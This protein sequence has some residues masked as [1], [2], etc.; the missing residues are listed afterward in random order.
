MK[1]K[2]EMRK[3]C[4]GLGVAFFFALLSTTTKAQTSEEIYDVPSF[5]NTTGDCDTLNYPIHPQWRR[6][7]YKYYDEDSTVLGFYNGV[8]YLGDLQKA[9]YFD[10]SSTPTMSYISAVRI[11][12]NYAYS[13]VTSELQKDI[14]IKILK[15]DNGKP[16]EEITSGKIRYGLLID[17]VSAANDTARGPRG[18]KIPVMFTIPMDQVGEVPADGKFYVSVD[19]SNLTI[20]EETSPGLSIPGTRSDIVPV[21]TAWTMTADGEWHSHEELY[22]GDSS[23]KTTLYIFPMMSSI[24]TGCEVLPVKLLSFNANRTAQNVTLNW[25]VASEY[26]MDSYVI[27]RADNNN[28][29]VAVGSV[30]AINNLK[31][32]EYSFT[33]NNAFNLSSNVQYR[34]KQVNADGSSVYSRIIS[35][36]SGSIISDV[37][38]ANPFHNALTVQLNLAS[39]EKVSFALYNLQGGM[40][41]QIAPQNYNANSNRVVLNNTANL[42]SGMYILKITAGNEQSVFKVVK[43]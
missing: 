4:I 42:P 29:F 18:Y 11:A 41:A 23:F 24:A 9:N 37:T 34:L 33:D 43:Q 36:N 30:N 40:V 32:I 20:N 6:H 15:D 31:D 5:V 21:N 12:F 38:F 10:I 39:A 7:L 25:K 3:L 17:S 13:P 19:F 28:K 8:S 35:V 2:N 22:S 16:G 26:L 27:E 1:I 14:L